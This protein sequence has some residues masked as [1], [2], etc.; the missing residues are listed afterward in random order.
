M[1]CVSILFHNLFFQL[2][3]RNKSIQHRHSLN[4]HAGTTWISLYRWHGAFV[5]FRSVNQTSTNDGLT[6]SVIVSALHRLSVAPL[7]LRWSIFLH[8]IESK[9]MLCYTLHKVPPLLHSSP[10]MPTIF[11][12]LRS[13]DLGLPSFWLRPATSCKACLY[14]AA[15]HLR[16]IHLPIVNR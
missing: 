6:Q 12:S 4:T 11:A 13:S 1:K 14:P 2:R 7:L 10:S 3:I 16:L 5:S 8:C 9:K 15:F